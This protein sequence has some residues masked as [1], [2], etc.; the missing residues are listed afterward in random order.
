[1]SG[2]M[3]TTHLVGVT[4]SGESKLVSRPKVMVYLFLFHL[5][6]KFGDS[7][8]LGRVIYFHLIIYIIGLL[9]GLFVRSLRELHLQE[10]DGEDSPF[11]PTRPHIF[12]SVP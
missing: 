9:T 6:L 2:S 7:E 8:S 1:M 10:R 5:G 11:T 3:T 4:L 12:T